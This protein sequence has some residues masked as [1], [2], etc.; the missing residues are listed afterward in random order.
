VGEARR[1]TKKKK[2]VRYSKVRCCCVG[3]DAGKIMNNGL[4]NA[5]PSGHVVRE[6][7][8]C[9]DF[10]D[11]RVYGGNFLEVYCAVCSFLIDSWYGMDSWACFG[12]LAILFGLS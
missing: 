5:F 4:V 11:G 6:C 9:D 10:R 1:K 3:R 2:K 12:F 7:F 8:S